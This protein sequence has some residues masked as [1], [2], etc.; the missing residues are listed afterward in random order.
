MAENR[1]VGHEDNE[2]FE[3]RGPF[4]SR[5][6]SSLIG[7]LIDELSPIPVTEMMDAPVA[8][9]G[10]R[11]TRARNARISIGR[12]CGG[13]RGARVSSV[14]RGEGRRGMAR[15]RASFSLAPP[16]GNRVL[17][18]IFR[19]SEQK[20]RT[21]GGASSSSADSSIGRTMP[22][23]LF[24]FFSRLFD[25]GPRP[26]LPALPPPVLRSSSTNGNAIER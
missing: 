4:I 22:P 26:P 25:I 6:L 7:P 11:T 10:K 20:S 13:R 2:P 17:A 15:N 5:S 18:S 8:R 19:F 24:L 23:P 9:R 21:I 12:R 16:L 3:W 14:F 1:A